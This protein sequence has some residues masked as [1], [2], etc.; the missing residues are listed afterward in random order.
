[1]SSRLTPR[2]LA[3]DKATFRDDRLFIVATDDTYAP[4]QYF[5]FFRFHRLQVHVIPTI[6]GTSNAASVLER[7]LKIDYEVGD[8]RWLLLDVDHHA[9]GPHLRAFAK[10]I[11]KAVSKG[12]RVALSKPSFEFWLLLHHCDETEVGGLAEATAVE[13]AL[14]ELLGGYNKT[15]LR[16]EDFPL[17]RVAEACRRARRL[18]ETVGNHS[19]PTRNT[20][21]V[22]ALWESIVSSAAPT[23][24]PP[25]LLELRNE[26]LRR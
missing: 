26:I 23:Q 17:H 24:L 25:P 7:L 20:S 22:Y 14:R 18:D 11:N 9:Q 16:L 2:P 15:R 21:R 8:E 10:A 6:D 3:R 19:I 1:M 13:R 4:K 5:E 12:V